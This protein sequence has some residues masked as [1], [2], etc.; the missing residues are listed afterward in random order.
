MHRVCSCLAS[1]VLSALEDL[2]LEGSWLGEA[3]GD[4]MSGQLVVAVDDGIELVLHLLNVQWVEKHDLLSLAIGLDS[5]G[6][7]SDVG[8][9]NL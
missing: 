4:L 5:E 9:E 6:S 2:L 8:W 7:F 1:L 3:K